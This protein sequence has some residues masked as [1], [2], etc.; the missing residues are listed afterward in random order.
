MTRFGL[1]KMLRAVAAGAALWTLAV[2][3]TPTAAQGA[4]RTFPTPEAAVQALIDAVKAGKLDA[5]KTIF[6]PDSDDLIASSDAATAR[7]NQQVFVAAAG[8][9]WKLSD[10]GSNRRTLVIGNEAWPFPVPLVKARDG[11]HF[12]TAA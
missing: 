3:P 4:H 10:Q 7:G 12:D 5:V 11:W 2:A 6:G 9:G 1:P 8:E